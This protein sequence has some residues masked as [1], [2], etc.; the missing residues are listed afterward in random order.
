MILKNKKLLLITSLL[1]LLPIPI[2]LL[3]WNRFPETI[4]IHFGITGQADGFS[5]VP[6]AVFVPPLL[7]LAVHW[8]CILAA[9]LDKSNK[10]R[11]QKLQSIV[12]WIIP[13]ISNLCSG[14]MFALALGLEFSPVVWTLVPMGLLFLVIGNYMPKTRMNAT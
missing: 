11:N 13:L 8:L 1:T 2:G 12:L 10:E 9:A 4:A 6:Y 5:S 7:I 14:C 3:L